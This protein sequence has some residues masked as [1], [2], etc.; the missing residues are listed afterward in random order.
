M[1]TEN[2]DFIVIGGGSGGYAAARTALSHTG[3]I[4]IIDGADELGGLCILRGCM[5][6]K[7]LIFAADVLHHARHGEDFGLEIP[8]ARA[9][10]SAIARRTARMIGEFADYRREALESGKFVLYRSNARFTGANEIELADGRRLRGKKFLIATGSQV[11]FPPV[12]GLKDAGVWT[13]DDILALDFVPESVIVLGA[14]TV[15]CELAQFL[16]RIGSRVTL[17]QRS[18]RILTGLREETAR[19]VEQTFVE[20]GMELFTGSVVQQIR[21]AGDEFEAVFECHGERIARRASYCLNA[22]GRSPNTSDLG[23]AEAGVGIS[24]NGRIVT[25]SHQQTSNPNIYAAGDCCGPHDIVH[26]AVRQGETAAN[27][28]FGKPGEPVPDN[29]LLQVIFTDPQVAVAGLTDPQLDA[30]GRKFVTASYPFAEHGKSILMEAKRGFVRI[31]ADVETGELL[32]AEIVG[33][34]GGEL[35]HCLVV[36]ITMKATVF[37][38]LR[39]PWYHPTLAEIIS[40]PVEEIA[41]VILGRRLNEPE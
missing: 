17:I 10:M 39:V 4:A 9:D 15:G 21:R 13:S 30:L 22:L 20:E 19:V 6:S 25:D 27:H 5:P 3:R 34:D 8:V 28:A 40:Y 32:G 12:P 38:L 1:E 14:G 7:A 11:Q 26:L 18:D 37:D 33:R 2:Y 24:G 29:H 41:E 35:I 16:T 36:A 23:L 31:A